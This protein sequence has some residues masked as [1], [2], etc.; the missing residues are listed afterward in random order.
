MAPG[1]SNA[2]PAR[3][4][5]CES[6][7]ELW[8]AQSVTLGTAPWRRS[9]NNKLS[10]NSFSFWRVNWRSSAPITPVQFTFAVFAVAQQCAS[11]DWKLHMVS[12]DSN[13]QHLVQKICGLTVSHGIGW[14]VRHGSTERSTTEDQRGTAGPQLE[15]AVDVALALMSPGSPHIKPNIHP[16]LSDYPSPTSI[17]LSANLLVEKL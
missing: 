1:L 8:S 15:S 5:R 3:L 12:H 7:R 2:A 10:S 11:K 14:L 17:L 6:I 13:V 16:Q 4:P 9:Y